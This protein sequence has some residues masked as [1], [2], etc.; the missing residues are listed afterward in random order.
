MDIP[1]KKTDIRDASGRILGY[2]E[3]DKFGNQRCRNF[4]GVILGYYDK[5]TDTTRTF[6]G[7]I[8]TRGNS[9]IGFLYKDK[10]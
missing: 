7:R 3:E 2:I 8:V 1:I 5:N 4:T 6:T 9:C 10:R